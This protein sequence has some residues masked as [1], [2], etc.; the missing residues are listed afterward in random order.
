M[1][2]NRMKPM[3][4]HARSGRSLL[5]IFEQFT[6]QTGATAQ[7]SAEKRVVDSRTHEFNTMTNTPIPKTVR[8]DW[9]LPGINKGDHTAPKSSI[10]PTPDGNLIIAG[11]TG[12]IY[13]VT[14]DGT[15]NWVAGTHPSG[16]GIHGT[17]V[18]AE[19]AV[20][21]GAYDGAL[22]AFDVTTGEQQWRTQFGDPDAP[23]P[24]G[25]G[26][27]GSPIYHEGT[28]YVAVEF[29]DPCP[30]GGLFAVDATTGAVEHEDR[31]PTSH[32]H[33]T[34]GIDYETGTI[35]FGAND[36]VLYAW[37]FP[38][39]ERAWSFETDAPDDDND[40]KGPIG[41]YDGAFFFGS[42]NESVYRVDAAT[43]EK[44]WEFETDGYVMGGTV[45]DAE[46]GTVYTGSHDEHCY[47][48]D[49]ASGDVQW[50]FETDG[51]ITGS[52]T[53]T[54]EHVLIGSYDGYLYALDKE[55]G[56]E[57]WSLSNNGRITSKPLVH[58]GAIYYTEGS[59]EDWTGGAYRYSA[60]SHNQSD[61]NQS[62]P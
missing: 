3:S 7:S 59:S 1:P 27:G 9:K 33:S 39:L 16:H 15:V 43:G 31:W 50:R 37:S 58:D 25:G 60:P 55:S 14:P 17:P 24:L 2:R 48:L 18:V 46:T 21:I 28:I 29:A 20:Y 35:A 49:A 38:E 57:V 23:S 12:M 62:Q 44:Q 13:S 10:V 42:W 4:E 40:V 61:D 56:E 26:I 19:G 51:W 41:V 8:Q 32:P 6:A 52:P 54:P 34:P 45:V 22:Y 36:G 47:A 30:S 5:R 11:D 53:V